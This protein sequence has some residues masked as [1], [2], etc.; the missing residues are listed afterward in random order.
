MGR[1][2]ND[3]DLV[4]KITRNYTVVIDGKRYIQEGSIPSVVKAVIN[5]VK[6][7]NEC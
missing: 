6:T 2:V 5:S 7:K 3:Y 1:K 4:K